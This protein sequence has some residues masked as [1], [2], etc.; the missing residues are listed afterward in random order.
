MTLVDNNGNCPDNSGSR[1]A[2]S[3]SINTESA[4]SVENVEVELLSNQPSYPLTEMTDQTGTF[5]FGN[6][7][8]NEDYQ[9]SGAKNDDYLNGVST[10]DL[11]VIQR[12]I[13]GISLL[14]SPYKI[15]A[16]DINNDSQINGLDLVELRKLI[17][18]IYTEFPQNDSWRFLNT[19]SPMDIVYPWPLNEIRTLL[20]ADTDMMQEDFVGVKIGD[21]NGDA[22]S[23]LNQNSVSSISRKGLELGF[24]NV[25]YAAGDLVEMTLSSKDMVEMSGLQFTMNTEGLE[26]VNVKGEEL[27]ITESNFA[28]LTEDL[29]TFSWND[30]DMVKAEKLFTLQFRAKESGILSNTVT[31]SSEITS[32]EAYSSNLQTIPVTLTGRNNSEQEFALYQNSPN[33]FNG[34]TTISFNLPQA[35]SATITVTDVTGKTL[36]NTTSTF[37]KGVNVFDVSTDNWNTT[38]ILYYKVETGE[39][40]ATKKMIVLK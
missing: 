2:I 28:N 40:S 8:R 32:A 29:I 23:N 39:Y 31:I 13:L 21:V 22:V 11:V 33:P 34:E 12:H 10:L 6:T 16:A 14:D 15:I 5:M 24:D 19:A 17:L 27:D 9:L 35:G 37:N 18:G 30:K 38:G 36:F 20:G 1:I 26:L 3:G 25:N 4:Q 7:V